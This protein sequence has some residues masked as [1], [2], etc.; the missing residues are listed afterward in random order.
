M[1]ITVE[2]TTHVDEAQQAEPTASSA[3]P[4]QESNTSAPVAEPTEQNA[5]ES[6]T[7]EA[8]EKEEQSDD[9][10]DEGSEEETESK[11]SEQGKPKKKG[12]FQRRIDKLSERAR[13]A[14]EE[15][16]Y[17]K[18]QALKTAGESKNTKP[19]VEKPAE[20]E[21]AGKPNPDNFDT[22]AEYVEALTD[23]KLEQREKQRALEAR[24]TEL[25][26]EQ[27]RLQK[28]HIQRV[29][30][31]AEKTEDFQEVLESVDDVP[32]SLV[33]QEAILQSENGPELMYELAKN[34]AE[35][36]RI[37]QLPPIAAARELGRFEAKLAASKPT[38]KPKEQKKTT[39][40]PKPI[41]PVG[42][43]RGSVEK[44]IY[45]SDLSQAEYE[46]LRAKQRDAR[47]G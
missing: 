40:A 21:P 39:Q 43:K 33:V 41:A 34:R 25:Q 46:R 24:K 6:D 31:F 37:N 5:S 36:E 12:G 4:Q 14:Q 44:S 28:A 8:E 2:S 22:H 47:T 35:Y 16:E 26:T 18:Q 1:S 29:Q 17:W 38:D 15:A 20:S 11:D 45:D 13:L 42:G 19:Q 32:L 30:S 27:E 10:K 3:K 9:S 7:E 23:W